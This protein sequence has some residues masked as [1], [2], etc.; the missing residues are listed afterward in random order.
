MMSVIMLR[1]AL[2]PG[3]ETAPEVVLLVVGIAEDVVADALKNENSSRFGP[4]QDDRMER[5]V[6]SLERVREWDPCEISDG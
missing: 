2:T 4:T 5:E 3:V 6:A 1:E